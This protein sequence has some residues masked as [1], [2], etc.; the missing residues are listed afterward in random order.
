MYATSFFTQK[1]TFTLG[2]Q[3]NAVKL[4]EY[5]HNSACPD[6]KQIQE[7]LIHGYTLKKKEKKKEKNPCNI[8]FRSQARPI[9][10]A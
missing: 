1:Y 6:M 7:K 8:L 3:G 5:E 10:L 9:W 2:Q 4:E